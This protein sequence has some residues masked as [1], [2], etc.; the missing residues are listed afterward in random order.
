MVGLFRSIFS[1]GLRSL[2]RSQSGQQMVQVINNRFD[3]LEVHHLLTTL[4]S[5]EGA[6]VGKKNASK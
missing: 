6:L 3:N 4:R 1:A 5:A 2:G